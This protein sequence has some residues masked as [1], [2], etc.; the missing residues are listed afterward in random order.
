M[1]GTF[2]QSLNGR[3]NVRTYAQASPIV[4]RPV[5]E[6]GCANYL[7]SHVAFGFLARAFLR[8]LA[9]CQA[10]SPSLPGARWKFGERVSTKDWPE[11]RKVFPNELRFCKPAWLGLAS[12]CPDRECRIEDHANDI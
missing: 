4:K 3:L 11:C 6:W 7:D 10:S 5:P 9:T 2:E 12:G 8:R 1:L